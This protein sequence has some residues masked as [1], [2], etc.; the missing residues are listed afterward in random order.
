MPSSASTKKTRCPSCS[1]PC[2]CFRSLP[3]TGCSWDWATPARSMR[4]HTA[5]YGFSGA[6]A[7]ENSLAPEKRKPFSGASVQL[8]FRRAEASA[9]PAAD[10]RERLSGLAVRQAADYYKIPPERIIVLSDDISLPVG[11]SAVRRLCRRAQR[12]QV[13]HF[14]P[15]DRPVPGAIRSASAQSLTSDYEPADCAGNIP[16]GDLP[17]LSDGAGACSGRGALPDC[18][19]RTRQRPRSSTA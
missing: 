8:R 6:D 1:K 4:A 14:S 11:K 19:R 16:K 9:R 10:V 7:L 2:P 12:H 17:T 15:R 3:A 5:Q 13:D 18:R